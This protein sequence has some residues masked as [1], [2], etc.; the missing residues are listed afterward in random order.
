MSTWLVVLHCVPILGRYLLSDRCKGHAQQTDVTDRQTLF[1]HTSQGEPKF[2]RW[3]AELEAPYK[4][5]QTKAAAKQLPRTP[6]GVVMEH[7]ELVDNFENLG[8]VLRVMHET[9][10]RLSLFDCSFA[11]MWNVHQS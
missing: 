8:A 10:L 4:T 9:C 7:T 3:K 1:S 2:E 5:S 11:S 6:A